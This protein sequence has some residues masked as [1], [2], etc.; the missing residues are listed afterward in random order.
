MELSKD[1]GQPGDLHFARSSRE[2][3]RHAG[4]RLQARGAPHRRTARPE[5]AEPE[6]PPGRVCGCECECLQAPRPGAQG[7]RPDGR[8]HK[9]GASKS[10]S[11]ARDLLLQARSG[12]SR[13]RA[14][15]PVRPR[16][17]APLLSPQVPPNSSREAPHQAQ[18]APRNSQGTRQ[19]PPRSA[20]E[21]SSSRSRRPAPSSTRSR[22][23]RSKPPE[24]ASAR[25]LP[26]PALSLKQKRREEGGGRG[27]GRKV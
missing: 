16:R 7:L 12:F 22:G 23:V 24:H 11:D 2:T 19:P 26:T 13:G 9:G 6:R 14:A 27:G 17:S 5:G 20:L 25:S 3:A 21:P 1:P 10:R 15:Q 18:T 4:P 8:G